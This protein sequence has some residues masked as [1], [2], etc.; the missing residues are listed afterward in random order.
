M[1]IAR[2]PLIHFALFGFLLAVILLI[3]W[4]PPT[5]GDEDRRVVIDDSDIVQL[6]AAWYRQ[7]RREPTPEELRGLLQQHIREE[8]LYRE[9]LARGLDENDQVVRRAMQQKMEF[10]GEAQAD[11]EAP[12]A[13]EMEA[14]FA[15]RRERYRMPGEVSFTQLYFNRDRRGSAAESDARRTLAQLQGQSPGA[16]DLQA[17][18]DPIMLESSYSGLSGDQV[19]SLFGNDFKDA[20]FQLDTG[21][22]AGP[23]ESGYGLHLI[24]LSEKE[25]AVIPEWTQVK[26]ALLDDMESEASRAAKELFY[27]EILRNYQIVYRGETINL[28]EEEG[29]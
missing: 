29:Q 21:R 8:V 3:L 22:W 16:V 15:L 13:G 26:D 23:V 28:L 9:A 5:A 14:F 6:S 19:S 11:N 2:K 10:L 17:F 20:L 4:G 1:T 27:T 25:A 18:G 12:S 24:Y 7:W